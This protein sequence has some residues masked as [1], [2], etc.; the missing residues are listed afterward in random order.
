MAVE[1]AS[2]M[3]TLDI[4]DEFAQL[5]THV[6]GLHIGGIWDTELMA[7]RRNFQQFNA[8]WPSSQYLLFGPWPHNPNQS[9]T[10]ADRDYGRQSLISLGEIRLR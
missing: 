8:K 3:P 6:A 7:T 4:W 9:T 5:E 2:D 1:Q 10:Y